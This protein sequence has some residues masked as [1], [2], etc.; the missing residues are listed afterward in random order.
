MT[1]SMDLDWG[2]A[3]YAVYLNML[4]CGRGSMVELELPKLATR[5]RF[6]SPAPKANTSACASYSASAF[7]LLA[8]DSIRLLR[9][10]E[11]NQFF[12]ISFRNYVTASEASHETIGQRRSLMGVR[13]SCVELPKLVT[14]V[15]F[16]LPASQLSQAS[17]SAAFTLCSK[18]ECE[19]CTANRLFIAKQDDIG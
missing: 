4:N 19:T 5:V 14:R 9:A 11:W 12:R 6:P 16:L 15:R 3:V 13:T 17:P 2:L 10:I 8:T 7:A 1:H 18:T